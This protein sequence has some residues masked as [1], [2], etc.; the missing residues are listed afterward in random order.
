MRG[1]GEQEAGGRR[2]E[3]GSSC[4]LPPASCLL[5][6]LLCLLLLFALAGCAVPDGSAGANVGVGR[7]SPEAA[8]DGFLEDLNHAFQS[9]NLSDIAERRVWAERLAGYFA[10]SERIDQRAAFLDMLVGFADTTQHPIIGSKAVLAITYSRVEL[11]SRDGDK[12]M[13]WVVDGSFD[14]RWLNEKGEVMRERTGGLT[15]VLG[16]ASG[17]LP[18]LRVDG[19]WFLTER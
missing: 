15:D 3:A 16:Q 18:V 6:P 17:G 19:L 1:P 7:S 11:L 12:A 14:L 13:V 5:F 10:P 4:L 8:V 2:Q 9:P